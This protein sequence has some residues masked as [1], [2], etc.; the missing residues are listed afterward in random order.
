[1][2]ILPPGSEVTPFP[3][4]SHGEDPPLSTTSHPS[5]PDDVPVFNYGGHSVVRTPGAA[6]LYDLHP[7]TFIRDYKAG[8]IPVE[9][10]RPARGSLPALWEVDA[11]VRSVDTLS[12]QSREA[13]HRRHQKRL[14]RERKRR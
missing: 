7:R 14:Q 6:R 5:V 12:R 1:M 9:P 4:R 13:A 11:L 3:K 10:I 2:T 8:A